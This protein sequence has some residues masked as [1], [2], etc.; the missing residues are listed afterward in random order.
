MGDTK[1]NVELR[2]GVAQI[3]REV[4]D[5][6]SAADLHRGRVEA[7]KNIREARI[8]HLRQTRKPLFDIGKVLRSLAPDRVYGPYGGGGGKRVAAG[9]Q[10]QRAVGITAAGGL[11]VRAATNIGVAGYQ[12]PVGVGLG[13]AKGL[14]DAI[15]GLPSALAKLGADTATGTVHGDPLRGVKEVGSAYLSDLERRYGPLVAGNDKAF[16]E[17]I[18]KEGAAGEVLDLAGLVAGGGATAGRGLTAVA[19]TGR[20]GRHAESLVAVPRKLERVS[21]GVTRE[22]PLSPNFFRAAT[23]K[24]SDVR[25]GRAQRAKVERASRA[26]GRVDATLREAVQHGQLLPR[27]AGKVQRLAYAGEKGRDLM[28]MKREQVTEVDKGARRAVR[29]LSKPERVAFKYAMQLGATTPAAARAALTHLREL[30]GT[31]RWR[32]GIDVPE[33]LRA[34]NDEVPVIDALI[35]NADKAFTPR[36]AKVVRQEQ[37]RERRVAA[38]DPG[39]DPVQAQLRRHAQQAEVLGVERSVITRRTPQGVDEVVHRESDASYLRRVKRAAADAGLERPGYFPSQKRPSI[40]HSDR[41]IGG[42]RAVADPKAYTGALFRTGREDVRADV[43]AQG[44]ERGIKRKYNW[45]L[46]GKTFEK[47]SFA[48]G[49]NQ[50]IGQLLDELDRRGIDPGSVAFWNPRRY[51]DNAQRRGDHQQVLE[52]GEGLDHAVHDSAVTVKDL[53]TRPEDFKGTNGWSV[54]PRAVYDEIHADTKTSTIA[55]RGLDV[56]KGKQSRVLLGLSPAWLQFQVVSNALLTGLAGTGP[57]DFVKAQVWWRKLSDAEKAAVEPFVGMGQF[58][59]A[60]QQPHLGAAKSRVKAINQTVDAWRALKQTAFLQRVGRGNPLDV[61]FRADNAQNNAFRRSVLYSQ[62]K[63]DAYKRMG[64]NAK[65]IAGGH[66]RL[67][68]ILTLGPEKQMRAIIADSRDLERHAQHVND[69]LG[70]Y[71]TYT[72]RERRTLGRAVMFY[73]FLRFSLRFTFLTMPLKHPVMSAIV[74]QL[75]KLQTEEVRKLLGGDELPW[76]LGKLYFERNGKLASIDLSRAN[77]AANA[78]TNLRAPKDILGFLPP[79]FVSALDQAYSKT[80]F[81]DRPFRVEGENQGR[82]NKPYGVE[83]RARIFLD[84]M[85]GLAAPYRALE[86]ATQAGPQGDDSLLWSPR[87]TKYVKPEILQSIAKGEADRPAGVGGRLLREVVPLIPRPDRAPEI[88]A[89]IRARNAANA[90]PTIKLPKR[91]RDSLLHEAR[92]AAAADSVSTREREMLLREAR[93][94]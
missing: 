31:E 79:L 48:W 41:A 11:P 78:L 69:F 59:D 39:L 23:Q 77:P 18:K 32:A 84:Q 52:G 65:L 57:A 24:T 70:D 12:D 61:L 37:A 83:N 15:T 20:L 93:G 6:K 55:G 50:S 85:L 35:A 17:R 40:R 21:G 91:E 76:A 90:K 82:V 2:R 71:T 46:V 10:A 87:P 5:T 42:A 1:S 80:G 13:T 30:V 7:A 56:I 38:G 43:F 49:R 75:G 26:G 25:R 22:Q 28:R 63:R 88:A 73:G 53:A 72:A 68:H 51:K 16:R 47:H 66:S 44:L 4:R 33:V 62:V 67:V 58:H 9:T 27:R 89:S 94:G 8:E 19:R 60:I 92:A 45:N 81:R 54:V 36:L 14:R 64:V 3:Q 86:K 74:A 34:T 29:G